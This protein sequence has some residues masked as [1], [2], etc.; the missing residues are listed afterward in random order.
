MLLFISDISFDPHNLT[1]TVN[2]TNADAECL[3][4]AWPQDHHL[5]CARNEVQ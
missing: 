3:W 2:L 5:Q 1:M 4:I